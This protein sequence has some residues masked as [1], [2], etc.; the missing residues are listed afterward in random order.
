MTRAIRDLRAELDEPESLR[1][2][3]IDESAFLE[4]L[5]VLVDN[6]FNDSSMLTTPRI[7]DYDELRAI[8]DYAYRGKPID[9]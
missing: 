4:C 1:A 8:L 9:F 3:G 5:D 6:A 2:L 7:P